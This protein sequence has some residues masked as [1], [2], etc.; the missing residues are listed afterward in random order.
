MAPSLALPAAQNSVG[1]DARPEQKRRSGQKNRRATAARQILI[2]GGLFHGGG[3][4]HHGG[5]VLR[6]RNRREDQ[7]HQKSSRGQEY[8]SLHPVPPSLLH[9]PDGLQTFSS[10]EGY[11]QCTEPKRKSLHY[12]NTF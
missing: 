7:H 5:V 6:Q 11:P 9:L 12:L 4:F 2:R 8:R 10:R 3:F 1:Q